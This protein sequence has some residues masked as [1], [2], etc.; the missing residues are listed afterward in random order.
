[1]EEKKELKEEA[2]N[3]AVG[4]NAPESI[5]INGLE[6]IGPYA[7]GGISSDKDLEKITGGNSEGKDHYENVIL[8]N[9]D[10]NANLYF[11]AQE[12]DIKE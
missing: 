7:V 4:G 3:E 1:M 9:V 11:Q 8:N 2:W 6:A 12:L 10:P 5:H